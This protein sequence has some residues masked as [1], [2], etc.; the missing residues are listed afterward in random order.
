MSTFLLAEATATILFTGTNTSGL[1]GQCILYSS[2]IC[3]LSRWIRMG[4]YATPQS[5]RYTLSYPAGRCDNGAETKKSPSVLLHTEN[6]IVQLVFTFCWGISFQSGFDQ[7]VHLG[8]ELWYVGYNIPPYIF[9][10]PSG[11]LIGSYRIVSYRIVS[12]RIVSYLIVRYHI[13]VAI[14]GHE[15]YILC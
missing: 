9:I 7:P 5:G 4:V 10:E 13:A 11:G 8:P 6:E 2:T 12:Y 1:F 3:H 14:I 15:T